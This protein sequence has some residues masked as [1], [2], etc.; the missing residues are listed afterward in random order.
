MLNRAQLTNDYNDA[1]QGDFVRYAIYY[2]PQPGTP[3]R[4]SD[5]RGSAVPMTGPPC[6][7]FPR[8]V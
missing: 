5:A 4:Y 7:H 8:R 2:T 3:S 1:H 6:R